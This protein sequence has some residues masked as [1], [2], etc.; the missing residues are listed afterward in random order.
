M[1]LTAIEAVPV[2]AL[3]DA[4]QQALTVTNFARNSSFTHCSVLRNPKARSR[5]VPSG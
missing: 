4:A 3:A 2:A 5:K 1:T